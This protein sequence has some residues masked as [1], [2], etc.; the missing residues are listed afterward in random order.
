MPRFKT[1]AFD[2]TR[3]FTEHSHGGT[4]TWFDITVKGKREW[5]NGID[6]QRSA[7]IIVD[8]QPGCLN[9]SQL[10]GE[11]GRT[12]RRRT[13]DIVIP[14]LVRLVDLFR[15]HDMIIVYLTL[16]EAGP[17][18]EIACSPKRRQTKREFLI[19]KYSSGAFAT[20]A[21]DNILRENGIA[22][23]FFAGTDTAGCVDGT[24]HE[25]YDRSYQTILIE[26]ACMS[27]R[28]ELHDAAVKIWAYQGFVRTTDQVVYDYP[29]QGWVDPNAVDN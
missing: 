4:E 19:P 8:M 21:L 10:P 23:L 15:Q 25:A 3:F 29:W 1:Y 13:N 6:Q 18:P 20:S 24:I 9:W 14:N 5:L 22:T 26:D 12:H 11:L 7:L 27:C 2:N 16:G 28:Q 17:V